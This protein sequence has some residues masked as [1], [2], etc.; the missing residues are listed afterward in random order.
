MTIGRGFAFTERMQGTYRG[1]APDLTG[2]RFHFEFEVNCPEPRRPFAAITGRAKGRVTMDGVANDAVAEGTLEIAPWTERTVRYEFTFGGKDGRRY[3]FRGEKRIQWLR[4]IRSWTTLPGKVH[5][6]N[7]D[8]S[9]REV[10]EVLAR[11]DLRRDFG[12]LL[13]SLR[14]PDAAGVAE[15]RRA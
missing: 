8:G 3:R 2:G 10:A 1:T 5:E 15:A 9:S 6:L 11:F 7:A 4:P 13:K 12:A 14:R